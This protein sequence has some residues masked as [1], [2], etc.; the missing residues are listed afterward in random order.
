V[1][2]QC[3]SERREVVTQKCAGRLHD[4]RVSL[5]RRHATRP[6]L[7]PTTPT[8]PRTTGCPRAMPT[9]V[10]SR[11]FGSEI[12]L[13]TSIDDELGKGNSPNPNTPLAW[14]ASSRR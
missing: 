13:I 12:G 3:G 6:G 11:L 8:P 5:P 1:I 10:L 9:N 14:T 4:D 7:C 2:E